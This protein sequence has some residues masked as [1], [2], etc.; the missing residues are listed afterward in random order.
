MNKLS[1]AILWGAFVPVLAIGG[2]AKLPEP[3]RTLLEK[4]D[5][6]KIDEKAKYDGK[7][8]AASSSAKTLL[9]RHLEREAKAANLDAVLALKGLD[10]LAVDLDLKALNPALP[11]DSK[12][13]VEKYVT[14]ARSQKKLLVETVS[15]K[16][17]AVVNLL[18]SHVAEQ[19][20]AKELEFAVAIREE[21]K[22]LEDSA[23][24]M[25][26]EIRALTVEPST[27][28]KLPFAPS[29][30]TGRLDK[31]IARAGAVEVLNMEVLPLKKDHPAEHWVSVPKKLESAGAVV[32]WPT[33]GPNGVADYKVTTPG[34]LIIACNF[35][36]QGNSGGDW[37]ETRWQEEDFR[38]NGWVTLTETQVGGELI[39]SPGRYQ[40]LF[41]KELKAGETGKLRCNKYDPPYFITFPK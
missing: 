7:I 37:E 20:I 23:A 40:V 35:S 2:N 36:Y 6:F 16:Q 30:A 33:K 39:K 29:G 3:S 22:K 9:A 1:W 12:A 15:G 32:Y 5:A 27:R 28:P 34:Y 4:F 17:K 21:V 31:L 18:N 26:E 41:F 14:N 19:T 24:Q 38:K 25:A 11:S 8:A 13:I 10:E